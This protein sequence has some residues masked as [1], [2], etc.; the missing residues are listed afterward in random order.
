MKIFNSNNA[1]MLQFMTPMSVSGTENSIRD[2]NSCYQ[3]YFISVTI[4][5]FPLCNKVIV[6]HST[7]YSRQ[8]STTG[9]H[10]F[11]LLARDGNLVLSIIGLLHERCRCSS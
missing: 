4:T 5:H 9:V 6:P 2:D 3:L 10:Q 11:G 1:R 8:K 7:H